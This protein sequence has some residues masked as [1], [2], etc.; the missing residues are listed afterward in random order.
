MLPAGRHRARWDGLDARGQA[1]AS[2]VYLYTMTTEGRTETRK[3]LLL[4]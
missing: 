2:G 3:M 4:R 1:V